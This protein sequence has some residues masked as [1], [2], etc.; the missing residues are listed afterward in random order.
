MG[1]FLRQKLFAKDVRN[2]TLHLISLPQLCKKSLASGFALG[3]EGGLCMYP[4]K[5]LYEL[6]L[7]AETRGWKTKKSRACCG[8]PNGEVLIS[9]PYMI[10]SSKQEYS[11]TIFC[12]VLVKP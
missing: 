2:L 5:I 11:L 7:E 10:S 8:C 6:I 9:H 12:H 3:H 4:H 1:G